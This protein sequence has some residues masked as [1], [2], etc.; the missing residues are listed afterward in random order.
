VEHVAGV[1]DLI[2]V[3]G[4]QVPDEELRSILADKLRYDRVDRGIMFN[5]L[6]L[7]VNNGIATLEGQVLHPAD[8]ASALAIVESTPG[9][10]GVVD[11]VTVQPTSPYDDELRVRIARAIYGDPALQKYAIDPQA[12]IRIVVQGGKVDLYGV[13]DNPSDRQIAEMR[14]RQ[15]P[16]AFSVTNH[17]L[18]A[19]QQPK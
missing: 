17:I 10:K 7:G 18:V 8:K 1:R 16:G 4:K 19:N 12:P 15:V 6:Q 14:A 5:N 2:T 9:V 13:V 11:N 3:S